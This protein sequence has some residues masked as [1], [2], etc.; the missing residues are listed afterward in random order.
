MTTL[1]QLRDRCKQESDQVNSAFISDAEWDNYI[2]GSYQEIYGLTAQVYGDDYY[3]QS[4]ATGY[5]FT[6]T[7]LTAYY[8]LPS[9]FFKMLGLD[10]LYGSLNQ[11]TSLKP[12]GIGERNKFSALNSPIPA[13]GQQLRLFYIPTVTRL[14]LDADVLLT[15]ITANGWEEYVVADACIK[16]CGKEESDV[17]VFAARKA[18]LKARIDAE[19]AN[20]DA[21]SPAHI[22]DARGRGT[23]AMQYHISGS[24]L[25]LI[26]Y[27]SRGWP[28]ADWNLVD[29]GGGWY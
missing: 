28:D 19:A 10:V 1:L 26:G 21:G 25:W 5:T 2:N 17:S 6:T 24:N 9:D 18:E 14:V 8:A 4:P 11:W 12:F 22:Q 13:A 16:A 23:G 20:R 27:Q 15:P 7:G 3:V 29:Y